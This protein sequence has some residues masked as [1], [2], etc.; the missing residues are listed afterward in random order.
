[1]QCPYLS[2]AGLANKVANLRFYIAQSPFLYQGIWSTQKTF[3]LNFG[4]Q[5]YGYGH[6]RTIPSNTCSQPGRQVFPGVL[7]D[8]LW[9]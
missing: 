6:Q 5:V 3:S 1:M 4:K 8:I 9:A 2:L 7:P